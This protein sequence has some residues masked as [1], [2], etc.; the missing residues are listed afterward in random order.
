MKLSA[1]VLVLCLLIMGT[2]SGADPAPAEVQAA[3]KLSLEVKA[4]ML[5]LRATV[6]SSNIA[7]DTWQWR[8]QPGSAEDMVA[9]SE[10]AAPGPDGLIKLATPMPA[11]GWHRLEVRALKDG[12]IVREAGVTR[13]P[14]RPLEM[15]T[16]ERVAALPEAE[17]GAWLA[18]LEQSE[19]DSRVDHAVLAAECRE[20]RA[21]VSRPAPMSSVE[22]ELDAKTDAAWFA[23]AEASKLADAILSYQTPSGGWSKAVDYTAGPRPR[24]THWTTQ[25]GAGWH[26]CGTLD[27]HSTTAQI[28][29]LAQVHAATGRA[30]CR[31]GAERGLKWLLQAQF[32]NGG[33]PQV[34][35][36]EPGY[37]EA[38][39]L[40]DDAMLHA[41]EILLMVSQGEAPFA[42]LDDDWREKAKA[43]Y[44]KG[45]ACLIACQVKTSQGKRAV[46]CAQHDPLTLAPVAARLKEPPSLSGA[47]SA[48]VLRFLMRKG[49]V[50]DVMRGAIED[51]VAWLEAHKIPG[52]RKVKSA[53][54]R[55]DYVPDAVSTEVYW[56][57]FYDL[58]TEQPMFAGAQDGRVYA[59]FH[60]MAQH[61]KVGYDYFVTKP[62]DVVTR[63]LARWRKRLA[64]ETSAR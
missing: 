55:T 7:A 33:W 50:T 25:S 30:D 62:G 48:N 35:P 64:K 57:R 21:P 56:A 61:N 54:G 44:E 10:C 6:K 63:E 51:G 43:A 47:E 52:L 58:T 34:Y 3:P 8:V 11:G 39:T 17:R 26:Y 46:W 29:F 15:V 20:I 9:W 2:A 41:L 28:A 27:N 18:Y 53:E 32:P 4:D 24:G 45:L 59:S 19:E 1:G 60:E 22:F 49:P 37:H 16:C 40:N 23:S 14:P 5:A 12:K 31:A 36:L 13:T 38:I 42:F